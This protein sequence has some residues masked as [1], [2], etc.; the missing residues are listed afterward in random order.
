M[1]LKSFLLFLLFV[2]V[3]LSAQSKKQTT[4]PKKNN[5]LVASID[6]GKVVF[7]K[8]CLVCHQADG[9]GVYNMNPPLI[10][11][12][13]VLGPKDVLVRQILKGSRGTVEIEGDTFHNTM[14]AQPLTDEQ[15]ANVLTYVRNSFG[16]KASRVTP[17]EVKTIRAKTK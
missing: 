13:W 15:I 10:K 1:N 9:S 2:P 5:S 12:K 3:F 14:P 17:A 4:A 7:L 16:N 8:Y 6:S 11:T